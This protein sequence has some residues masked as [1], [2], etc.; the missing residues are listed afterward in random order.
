MSDFSYELKHRTGKRHGNAD[1]LSRQ[2]P[3]LDCKQC[4]AIE[5]RDGGPSRAEIE[6][7][8]RAADQV[9]K[10]Q[11]QDPVA[12]DQ[13][14]GRHA[15]AQIYATVQTGEPL[16]P[17]E[18]QL[19]GKELKRLHARREAL[20]IRPDG[21]LQICLVVN[22]K[23]RWCVICPP[24]IRKTVIWEMHGLAHAGMNR[25]MARVQLNWYWPGMVA[26]VRRIL[27]SARWRN[28]GVIS[29]QVADNAYI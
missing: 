3:C 14:T 2:T 22:Q 11:A 9:V 25:T 7:E 21:I 19:G 6:A 26:D 1:G 27:K 4:A 5:Q 15:V 24:S 28:L 20:R 12:K 10:V 17:E 29:P 8:L 18:L 16:M 23:A 13:A